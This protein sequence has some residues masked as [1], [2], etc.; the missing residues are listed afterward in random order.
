M[1]KK[2]QEIEELLRQDEFRLLNKERVEGNKQREI[3]CCA[4]REYDR[5]SGATGGPGGVLFTQQALLGERLYDVPMHYI[6]RPENYRVEEHIWEQMRHLHMKTKTV[7]GAA[8]YLTHC[9]EIQ[10]S[11]ESGNVPMLVCHEL[12]SAYGAYLMG[13]PY[14]VI[15]HQ[16]GSLLNEIKALHE[17]S[18]EEDEIVIHFMES[19]V[20]RYAHKVYFP[21]LGARQFFLETSTLTADETRKISFAETALYNTVPDES[22]WD[23][24]NEILGE[25]GIELERTDEVFL[26][27]GDYNYDKGM[28]LVP[29]FLQTYAAQTDKRIVW[30]A[31]GLALTDRIFEQILSKRD[32]WNFDAYLFDH[33][34]EHSKVLG[35]MAYSDYYIMLHRNSVFDIATLEA[36]RAGCG[37]ILSG[38][39]SNYEFNKEENVVLANSQDTQTT[40]WKMNQ[41]DRDIWKQLNKKVFRTYFSNECFQKSYRD[42]IDDFAGVRKG[43]KISRINQ[44]NLCGWKDRYKGRKIVICGAGSSLDVITEQEKDCVYIALNKA[45]F[46]PRIKFDLLFMQDI[47]V[48]C[49]LEEFNNYDC[50]KFYGIITN[51]LFQNLGLGGEDKEFQD[52]SGQIYRYELAEQIFQYQTEEMEFELERYALSDAQSVLF[53]ALQFAIF[54]GAGEIALCGVDFSDI[55]YG[56]AENASRYAKNVVNNLIAFKK[57]IKKYDPKINFNFIQTHNERLEKA[58]YAVDHEE[59]EII[60][61]GIYTS[62]YSD[63]VKLQE[64]TCKDDYMFDFRY[65]TDAEWKRRKSSEGFAFFGGN[66][67]KTQLV[68]DKIKEYWGKNL[69]VADADLIFLKRTRETLLYELRDADLLFLRERLDENNLYSRAP[70]NVNIGFVCMRCNEESLRFWEKVQK[71]VEEFN[72]WDQEVANELLCKNPEDWRYKLLPECFLNGGDI[73]KDNIR[74]QM[75]CTSCGTIARRNGLEKY[76]FLRK[77]YQLSKEQRWFAP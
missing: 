77:A 59:E 46:Y 25:Y 39:G 42:M 68:I 49:R 37:M 43:R 71:E 16:Q 13:L 24:W 21:S 62:D 45:L 15:Y 44:K 31:F 34:I 72:G 35:L 26:S 12:G 52:V 40:V 50:D 14:V 57:Q 47:P 27:I 8:Y 29:S 3:F 6:F 41:M 60:V 7:L 67:I 74:R 54:S 63:M 23:E 1:D 55:N 36:M 33:R 17:E 4:Y 65:I 76:E 51:P 2:R 10:R 18:L 70:A 19:E 22:E 11:I 56:S 73:S 5:K 20:M 28:D 58:F 75:I 30:I 32:S 9:E 66:T 38:A 64:Q 69:L 53:S 61:S 48:G